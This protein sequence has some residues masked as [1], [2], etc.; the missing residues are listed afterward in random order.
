MLTIKKEVLAFISTRG[1]YNFATSMVTK[2]SVTVQQRKKGKNWKDH[3]S[4]VVKRGKVFFIQTEDGFD[5]YPGAFA[6]R[7]MVCKW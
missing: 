2:E 1:L 5:A 4:V 6:R 3:D 7:S